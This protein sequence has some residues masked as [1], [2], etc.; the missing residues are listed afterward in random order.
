MKTA[1]ISPATKTIAGGEAI[2][3][4]GG[5]MAGMAAAYRLHRLGYAVTVFE[6][7]DRVG[8]RMWSL[9]KGGFLMDVGMSAYLGTYREAIAL[10]AE[11]GLQSQMSDLPAIGGFMRDGKRYRFNYTRPISTALTT[12]FLSWPDK[13]RAIRLGLDTF[14]QRASLG[15]SDYTKLAA[16]DVE[17]VAEYAKRRLNVNLHHYVAQPLVSGT[18][19]ADD[20]DTSIALLYWTARNMLA[21]SVFNLNEGVMALPVA[22][23]KL[24]DVR[25]EHAVEHVVDTGNAVEITVNGHT[26]RFDGCVI[27]TTAQ[28]A[29]AMYPQMDANTRDLYGTTRYRRLG[30]ICL[31]LSQRP[32]DSATYYLPSPHEDPDTIAVIADHNKAP[33][34][35]PDGKGLLTVLLSHEYLERS[36]HRSDTDIL[37]YALN[38]ASK[39]YP[40]VSGGQLEASNVVRWA[41]SV[42]TIEKGRFRRIADYTARIDR[43]ARVQFASDLDRIPGCNGALVSGLEAGTRLSDALQKA[44]LSIPAPAL[45]VMPG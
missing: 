13:L 17:T 42:P 1:M 39:Y 33:C 25:C 38:R 43:N 36:E 19:A 8:G 34:R 45:H 26:H 41:E 3:I 6:S 11:L 4:I 24:V 18:W 28:P 2:A 37:D 31:G 23:S 22:I 35:A 30:N 5:G 32:D 7:R 16:I 10:M 27:A 20:K 40:N 29:L 15:Y 21:P 12:S 44:S 9:Q 14:R